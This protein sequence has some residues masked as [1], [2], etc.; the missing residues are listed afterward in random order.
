M[1]N[2]YGTD[3]WSGEV[4]ADAAYFN[5]P[6]VAVVASTGDSGYGVS[7]PAASPDVVAVGGTSLVQSSN[8]GT[9]K[10]IEDGVVARWKWM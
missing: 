2:S 6:G 10:A 5:H 9:R 8:T 3:E 1:S 4:H 7:Y